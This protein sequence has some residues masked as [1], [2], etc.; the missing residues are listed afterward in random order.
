MFFLHF[1]HPTTLKIMTEV[2]DRLKHLDEICQFVTE[3]KQW[4]DSVYNQLGWKRSSA[5]VVKDTTSPTPIVQ[6]Q[7]P[8]PSAKLTRKELP[9]PLL[10]ADLI[11]T[12]HKLVDKEVAT[13]EAT[14]PPEVKR[15]KMRKRSKK[16]LNVYSSKRLSYTE[17]VRNVIEHQNEVI[18]KIH[19]AAAKRT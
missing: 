11:K 17:V 12:Y 6:P 4:I 8:Q 2:E 3:K 7:L 5:E 13:L 18:E 16:K 14:E 19:K 15:L 1:L 9:D 10:N